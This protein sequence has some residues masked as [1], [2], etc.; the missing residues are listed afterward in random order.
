M[1]SNTHIFVLSC[2]FWEFC[3]CRM[4]VAFHCI[5]SISLSPLSLLSLPNV[6][7]I[8][9]IDSSDTRMTSNRFHIIHS[10][11]PSHPME[12]IRRTVSISN[13]RTLPF[14]EVTINR[15]RCDR[16]ISTHGRQTPVNAERVRY[17]YCCSR[18]RRARATSDMRDK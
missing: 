2:L 18:A 10:E 3:F 15:I 11:Y 14:N 17:C 13:R 1:L 6:F 9:P 12:R 4:P 16:H 7:V 8:H 5:P